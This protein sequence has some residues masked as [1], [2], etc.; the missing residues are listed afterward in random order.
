MSE[1]G[2]C[3]GGS[4]DYE[5]WEFCSY[6]K[7]KARKQHKCY[8]CYRNISKGDVHEKIS[9]KI[10]GDFESYRICLD[11]VNIRDGLSCGE[12]IGIGELWENVYYIF[13]EFNTNCLAK[14][15]TV[16]AKEYILERWRKW[17]G[18]T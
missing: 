18:L 9:G 12:P 5:S 7:P 15:K 17:K 1:C 16:S 11:C 8:E 10:N 2:I 13:N 6:E 14:I 3:I 4:G